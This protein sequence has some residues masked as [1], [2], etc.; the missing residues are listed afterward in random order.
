MYSAGVLHYEEI[1]Q[2]EELDQY[3][4]APQLSN[5]LCIHTYISQKCIS[6]SACTCVDVICNTNACDG[7][8]VSRAKKRECGGGGGG[9]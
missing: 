1:S 3:A 8:W 7:L 4:D 9:F 5:S 6:V 2:G